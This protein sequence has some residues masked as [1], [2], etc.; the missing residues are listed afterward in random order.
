MV[1]TKHFYQMKIQHILLDKL[2]IL[3]ILLHVEINNILTS[4]H[5]IQNI[6]TK[7]VVS[8]GTIYAIK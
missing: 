5:Y 1:Y 7:C 3:S 8:F 4:V 2:I 6:L